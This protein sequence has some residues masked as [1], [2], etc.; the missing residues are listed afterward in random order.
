ML[1]TLREGFP[2]QVSLGNT[3]VSSLMDVSTLAGLQRC[4]ETCGKPRILI[5]FNPAFPKCAPLLNNPCCQPLWRAEYRQ[6]QVRRLHGTEIQKA[7]R[8]QVRSVLGVRQMLC[9]KAAL[10]GPPGLCT[11]LRSLQNRRFRTGRSQWGL[12]VCVCRNPRRCPRCWAW[13]APRMVRSWRTPWNST[14]VCPSC[15]HHSET[16]D[17]HVQPFQNLPIRPIN[18]EVDKHFHLPRVGVAWVRGRSQ[19]KARG[20]Q[21]AESFSAGKSSTSLPENM[22]GRLYFCHLS[23]LG[24]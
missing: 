23:C 9:P 20:L 19:P 24:K 15:Q 7:E 1:H 21:E 14:R 11:S 2:L 8:P 6:A 22:T 18:R 10:R 12:S 4:C 16:G 17:H 5:W 3:T 13:T